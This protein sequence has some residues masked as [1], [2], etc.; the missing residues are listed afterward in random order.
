MKQTTYIKAFCC[1]I[2]IKQTTGLPVI[3]ELMLKINFYKTTD[4]KR[5]I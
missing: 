1:I 3:N 5:Y 2:M 4:S